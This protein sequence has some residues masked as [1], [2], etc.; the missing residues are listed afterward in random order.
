MLYKF[1]PGWSWY[2]L[3]PILKEGENMVASVDHTV[4][5]IMDLSAANLVPSGALSQINNAFSNPKGE[6]F[7]ITIII[8]PTTFINAMMGMAKKVW[9]S[10]S[11]WTLDFVGTVDEAYERI[12][13]HRA[14]R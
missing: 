8:T 6:N 4:D 14:N 9:G 12:E 13:S 11:D 7:G 2:D 10:K 3:N 1:Y 5:V